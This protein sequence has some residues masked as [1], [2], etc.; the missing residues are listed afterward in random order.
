LEAALK[1]GYAYLRAHHKS[2]D[3]VQGFTLLTAW[4]HPSK[5][6]EEAMSYQMSGIAIRMAFELDLHRLG[7]DQTLK[8]PLSVSAG[9]S[10]LR[11][12]LERAWLVLYVTD[13]SFSATD[14]RPR[15]I[16]RDDGLV[17][18]VRKWAAVATANADGITVNDQS[19]AAMAD[20]HRIVGPMGDALAEDLLTTD[21]D[22]GAILTSVLINAYQC[23]LTSWYDLWVPEGTTDTQVQTHA[24]YY[25][26]YRV[27]LYS[28]GIQRLSNREVDWN[29]LSSYCATSFFCV[30]IIHCDLLN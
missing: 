1:E 3:V 9:F 2:I 21:T 12:E 26:Y 4:N 30:H 27:L 16:A 5:R 23:Q 25:H 15:M 18:G 14:G 19:L 10:G 22:Q 24:F 28:F 11:R 17:R 13:R 6:Y 29:Q 8:R 7:Q 20:L